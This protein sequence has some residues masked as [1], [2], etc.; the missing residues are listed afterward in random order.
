MPSHAIAPAT[1]TAFKETASNPLDFIE[2]QLY[3]RNKDEE[4]I[5]FRLNRAQR[6]VHMTKVQ[7]IEN[8]EDPRFLILKARREG[9]TTYEQAISFWRTATQE[10]ASA[11]TLAHEA[12]STE[13]IF[14]IANLFYDRMDPRW[15]PERRTAHNKRNLDFTGLNSLFYI[16]TAGKVGFARGDTLGR[17]HGSEVAHWPGKADE[18]ES[19]LAGL[20]EAASH[21]EVVLETTANG[22]SGMF[23]ETW[24]DAVKG[25]N[26]WVPIFLPWWLDPENVEGL[27]SDSIAEIIETLD[28]EEKSLVARHGLT[29]GQIAWRRLKRR[30]AAMRRLFYQE[31]PEDPETAFIVKAA[32]YFDIMLAADVLR[33]LAPPLSVNPSTGIEVYEEPI[34][35]HAYVI[36]CD[37]SEGV[38]GG[39]PSVAAVLDM[40]DMRQAASMTGLRRPEEFAE[41]IVKLAKRYNRAMVAVERQNHGHSCLNTLQNHIGYSNLYYHRDYDLTG[42]LTT[43][44]GWPTDQKTR[45]I[46]HSALRTA[47]EE[48]I[49]PIRDGGL[50]SEF[51]TFVLQ[52]GGK[53]EAGDN[54]TDDRIDAWSIA[55]AVR[56]KL[57]RPTLKVPAQEKSGVG[58]RIFQAGHVGS[59]FTAGKSPFDRTRRGR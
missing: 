41:M 12:E 2:S 35:G 36:G 28:D 29:P 39:N 44:L 27:D 15:R 50:L 45:P 10:N 38:I 26:E 32:T 16:G 34:E 17:V 14:R 20:T 13:I 40:T 22:R 52:P 53:Y 37:P 49:M 30:T 59:I 6:F 7:A 4:V 55:V 42:N 23:Y 8:G 57:H 24:K 19:L 54:D 25:K 48:E 1:L 51:F 11:V 33:D 56:E 46:M 43:K 3:I 9:V 18:Q 58:R 31:Y 21:G 5:P 47:F